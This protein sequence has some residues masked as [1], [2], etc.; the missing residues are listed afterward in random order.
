MNIRASL[1]ALVLLT[2]TVSAAQAAEYT[3]VLTDK[4][5][6]GFTYRQMNVPMEGGFKR[7][8]AQL[9]FDPAQAAKGSASFD[10]DV[11]SIDVGSP[12]GNGEIGGKALFDNAAHPAAR[13][14]SSSIKP[15]GN[16]RFEVAGKLTIKGRTRD[17]TA[18]VA[19]RQDGSN[20]V[21]EGALNIKRTDFAIGEGVWADTSIVADE[22]QIRFRL[23]AAGK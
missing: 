6:L 2:A 19:F 10:I 11:K 21:F 7:F 15:L 22:V 17:V 16:N 18:P 23:L 4:S 1:A 20:G 5:S 8:Q 12:D 13:F 3:R 14:V 9:A